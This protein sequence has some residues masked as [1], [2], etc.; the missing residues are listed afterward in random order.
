[1]KYVSAVSIFYTENPDSTNDNRVTE[2]VIKS[3]L[4]DALREFISRRSPTST[5]IENR[6]PDG[7]CGNPKYN[8]S[9][10]QQVDFRKALAEKILGNI[11]IKVDEKN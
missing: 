2:E 3:I 7:F 10:E 8:R 9:K 6:Y 4:Q 5:Y 11:N 1:M